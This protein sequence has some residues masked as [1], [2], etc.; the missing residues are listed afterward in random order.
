MAGT[1]MAG[2]TSNYNFD[3]PTSTDYVKD[4]AT[5]IQELADDVDAT[6][7]TALGGDYPG[8][9]LVKKQT[10]GSA[11]ASVTVTDAFSATYDAY[12]ILIIGGVSSV[13]NNIQLKLGSTVSGYYS[14]VVDINY[15]TAS[16]VGFG[17]NNAAIWQYVGYCTSSTITF[18]CDLH[19]PFAAK[20]TGINFRRMPTAVGSGSGTGSGFLNTSLSYTSFTVQPGS[21][22][23]TGGT[24][25]VYGYGAS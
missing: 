20:V 15:A 16:L 1:I 21:G 4:G 24:I 11:V 22:T 2:Q 25:Y 10:I 13:T 3:Y 5:A 12:K 7:F 14:G 9:R 18:D 8:L 6:L 23:F 17:D 19:N